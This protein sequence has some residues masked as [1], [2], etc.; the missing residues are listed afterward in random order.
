LLERCGSRLVRSGQAADVIE[1]LEGLPPE[2][3]TEAVEFVAGEARDVVGDWEGALACYE[4]AAPASGDIPPALAWRIARIHYFRSDL[5][6][7]FDTIG[8]AEVTSSEEVSGRDW[9][10][11]FAW[12]SSARWLRGDEDGCR[13]DAGGAFEL[14]TAA[15]D[16][17][18][19]SCAHTAL[20]MLAALEGDRVAND[21]H[22]LRALDYAVQAGDILQEVRVRNNRGSLYLEQ[23]Y[24]EEAIAE[25][26]LALR[27]ADLAGFAS[28]R[29]LALVNRGTAKYRLGRLEEAAGD[30]DEAR[31][32]YERLGSSDAAYALVNLAH[33]YRERGD[34][35]MAQAAF[36]EALRRSE[37]A[38]DV[39][40]IVPALAGLAVVLA[41]DDPG[42]AEHLAGAAVAYG[43][44]MDHTE[45]LLAAGWVATVNRRPEDAGR[46]A[47]E[48]AAEARSR[49]D[50]SGLAQALELTAL[51][52]PSP[53]RSV[54]AVEEAISLWTDLGSV[55]G[56]AR[57]RLLAALLAADAAGVE[58]AEA[59]LRRLGVRSHQALIRLLTAGGRAGTG[60]EQ[61]QVVVQTLGR[62]R[63]L[64]SG[65]PL[66]A[67]AWQS[68]KARELL[69][70]LVSR[71]G[72]PVP[73][74]ELMDLLWPGEPPVKLANRL[75]VALSTLR[76]AFDP[77]KTAAGS[78]FIVADRDSVRLDLSR[79]GV[80][81]EVFL[82]EAAEGLAAS[83]RCE[84]A[85][86][87]MLERAESGYAGD[88]LEENAYDDW[89]INLR[90]A[91]RTTYLQ[92]CRA[93]A[94][95]YESQHD[96]TTAGRYLR[97]LIERDPYD[98]A[99]HLWLVRLL[100]AGGHHGEAHG[101]YRSYSSR[102]REIGVEPA[103]FLGYETPG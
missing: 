48:A 12:R 81:V 23:G 96:G 100:V 5:D 62:L 77:D 88:F 29:A 17:E 18:A 2:V 69:K 102:M 27:S 28:F 97:R 103:P 47:R 4:R 82:A 86:I 55:T 76:S 64:V 74:E 38:K 79:V 22:Y 15:G 57:G 68:R 92:V 1:T 53:E 61:S 101:C 41:A 42:R 60:G 11:L 70:I 58:A 31:R 50:R 3:R 20:A 78:P 87:E 7:V 40:A 13:K 54:A 6:K 59:Q 46:F 37:D 63:V 43:P 10:L 75:S 99:A 66:P 35:A 36:E 25:L 95:A 91:A 8:E 14:A 56:Q 32:Q 33:V 34:L 80:D 30:L 24:F 21:A 73:R 19:L 52:D 16:P 85:A 98:E 72:R 84:P 45:A 49:R 93:L 94:E 65:R 39:Q 26:D 71:R 51:V 67:A 44:G 90:E 83:R 9:A 89:A